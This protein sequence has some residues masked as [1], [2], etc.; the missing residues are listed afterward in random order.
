MKIGIIGA[1]GYGGAELIRILQRHPEVGSLSL[2]SS[3]QAG[4]II[5]DTYPH[6]QRFTT[7]TLQDIDPET[8][9][10]ELDIVFTATPSGISSKLTPQLL[11]HGL[12]VIDL[13]GD[14][15]IKDSS[16][17]EKWYKKEPA[18]ADWTEKA[19]YGLTEWAKEDVQYAEL[20]ANPGCFPTATL[21]GLL[22]LIRQDIIEEDSIIVDAKTG[23]SGAGK[24]PSATSHFGETSENFR[25]YKVNQHQHIPEIEQELLRVNHMIQPITFSS[26]LVPMTRGIMAT[27]Y[28]KTKTETSAAEL[29]LLMKETYRD[30]PFVSI[31]KPGNFPGT[32]EVFGSN[33]C[34]I[35]MTYDQRTG[36]ITIVSVIDNLVKGAA[37]SAVQNFNVMLE[38]DEKTGLDFL[39]VYP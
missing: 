8:L 27:M 7:E 35:G 5:Q 6:L 10:K 30:A 34:D 16:A 21:L 12:K 29:Y 20:I 19:V 31:R 37:G 4:T 36:R 28:A 38:I 32:K 24:T 2:F 3:S 33:Q 9:G 25:I 17:Y 11:E 22:P 26:H 23:L 39:P 14:F 13:S 18:P 1:T 15:R